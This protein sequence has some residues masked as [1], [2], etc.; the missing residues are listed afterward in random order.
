MLIRDLQ[1]AGA[2][3]A[4]EMTLRFAGAR[5]KI[6]SHNIANIDTPDF[7]PIDVST[8]GFQALLGDA[9]ERR[10]ERTGGAFGSLELG[11]SRE[12]K[13][14][15]GTAIELRPD[16]HSGGVLHHDR[17]SADIERMMQDLVENAAVFRVAS[18]LLRSQRDQLRNAI[19]QRVL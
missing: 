8:K 16:T 17:N 6:L 13:Q 2:A 3:P 12:V 19:G 18:D 10:R 5:Q 4:L 11:R 9:I 1:T 15:F 7:R 14:G